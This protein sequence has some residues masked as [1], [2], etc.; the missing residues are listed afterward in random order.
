MLIYCGKIDH[1]EQDKTARMKEKQQSIS[2]LWQVIM[3]QHGI[4]KTFLFLTIPIFDA[5]F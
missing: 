1:R 3:S 5:V 4:T 2:S